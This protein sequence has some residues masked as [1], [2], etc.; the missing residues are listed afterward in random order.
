MF[1]FCACNLYLPLIILFPSFSESSYVCFLLTWYFSPHVGCVC[2]ANSRTILSFFPNYTSND[3]T[4]CYP[5]RVRANCGPTMR[6]LLPYSSQSLPEFGWDF[7]LSFSFIQL[8]DTHKSKPIV[9]CILLNLH[10][11]AEFVCRVTLLTLAL[12]SNPLLTL[13]VPCFSL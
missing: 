5:D 13:S 4:N 7:C 1:L 10:F 2:Q 12:P 8:H 6:G 3:C 9:P 11:D